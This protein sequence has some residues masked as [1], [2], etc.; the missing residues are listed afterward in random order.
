MPPSREDWL[1][2]FDTD[3]APA[4]EDVLCGYEV[5]RGFGPYKPAEVLGFIFERE[6][7]GSARLAALDE[8]LRAWL[9]ERLAEDVAGLPDPALRAVDLTQAWALAAALVL[10][11][12]RSLI[13]DRRSEFDSLAVM[14]SGGGQDTR[15]RLWLALAGMQTDRR[16]LGRWLE[17]CEAVGKGQ[18]E[19]RW[20]TISL[21][22]LRRLPR[23]RGASDLDP[24]L[25]AGLARWAAGLPD[26]PEGRERFMVRW[27]DAKALYP[28]DS[29]DWAELVI[30]LLSRYERKPFARWWAEDL[31]LAPEKGEA[32]RPERG[33]TFRDRV[34]SLTGH[35]LA[36][37]VATFLATH[38]AEVERSGD[39]EYLA[40]SMDAAG[41]GIWDRTPLAA[42]SLAR[43]AVDW[44]PE[45]QR[46]WDLLAESLA[47]CGQWRE[48]EAVL[49]QARARFGDNPFPGAQLA[50]HLAK[51]PER[52]AEAE[53]LCRDT[54][55]RFKGNPVALGLLGHLLAERGMVKEAEAQ[56]RAAMAAD[57]EAKDPAPRTDLARLL[58]DTGRWPE[59]RDVF[60][61][62]IAAFPRDAHSRYIYGIELVWRDEPERAAQ[63]QAELK[64][65][66]DYGAEDIARHLRLKAEGKPWTPRKKKESLPPRLDLPADYVPA[67]AA[68]EVLRAQFR[69]TVLQRSDLVLCTPQERQALA[70]EAQETLDRLWRDHRHHP[71]VRLVAA[72][73]GKPVAISAND[74]AASPTLELELARRHGGGAGQVAARHPA[75][76]PLAW[77]AEMEAG[78]DGE[79][80]G[81]KHL[82]D[83]LAKPAPA[84]PAMAHIH[85]LMKGWETM[86]GILNRRNLPP[87]VLKDFLGARFEELASDLLD[88][89]LLRLAE[90]EAMEGRPFALA[91]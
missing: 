43:A 45:E 63:M 31:G 12:S 70:R 9:V 34:R 46:R 16:L 71:V 58:A 7:A 57:T 55:R 4:L 64:R 26:T 33:D 10:P 86:P 65:M 87:A 76:A 68:W 80:R 88:I 44:Q 59:A 19:E 54:L 78:G 81:L 36:A 48:A 41:R 84:D 18:V 2:L 25:L 90:V 77:L 37:E 20:L 53:A 8:A 75:L 29:A 11:L 1:R 28:R 42:L 56:L 47:A 91:A 69:L 61:H 82:L 24:A 73:R 17:L 51:W 15:F 85:A 14:L 50:K 6:S 39:R 38:L 49:W 79:G 3:P 40:K 62:T 21:L 60:E 83:W 13:L 89:A 35:A 22:G 52:V 67:D 23:P 5:V 32:A 66:R 74:F 72:R 30:P 27:R